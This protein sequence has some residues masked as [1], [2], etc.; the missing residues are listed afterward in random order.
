MNRRRE[1]P[2]ALD[3]FPTPP[4][5]VRA[6]VEIIKPWAHPKHTVWEPACGEGHMSET[7][8][9]YFASVLSSDVFS[10]GYGLELDF[11]DDFVGR[12]DA[13][14]WTI[15]NPPFNVAVAFTLKA[16]MV[17]RV[18]VVMFARSNW[19]EG[20]KRYRQLWNNHPPTFEA[21]FSERV[22]LVKGR[23]DPDATTAT[24]YSL[25]IWLLCVAGTTPRS[26]TKI[27]IPPGTRKRLFREQDRR[28][29]AIP[30]PAPLFDQ[31]E[32]KP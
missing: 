14:D 15:T 31:R 1:P 25:W 4:W 22:A 21:C 24:A 11:L 23:Y 13:V 3:Y 12:T 16:L 9:E 10:Y 17:S 20:E 30:R 32:G 2:D 7:L 29:W 26:T 27:W 8:Q 6:L 19:A 28:R 18:G 5:C